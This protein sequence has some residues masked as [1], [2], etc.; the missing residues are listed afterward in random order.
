MSAA[1]PPHVTSAILRYQ[2]DYDPCIPADLP[3]IAALITAISAVALIAFGF[4]KTSI[5]FTCT[6]AFFYL[7]SLSQRM[8]ERQ[9]PLKYPSI[10]K[11][12]IQLE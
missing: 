11:N 4:L 5:V 6:A 8:N 12:L 1:S 2:A 3:S 9:A 7:F 10:Q